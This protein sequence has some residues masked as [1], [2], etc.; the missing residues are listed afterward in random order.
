MKWKAD[1]SVRFA[2]LASMMAGAGRIYFA[3]DYILRGA[4]IVVGMAIAIRI[5]LSLRNTNT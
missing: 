1:G 4:L 3:H 2:A 5:A